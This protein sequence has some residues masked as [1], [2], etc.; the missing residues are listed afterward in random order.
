MTEIL[1]YHLTE[2]PL[3]A[4][5][6][7]LLEKSLQRGWRVLVLGTDA[8]RMAALDLHLWSWRDDSF[9]PHGIAGGSHDEDQP[10]L[11]ATAPD[12]SARQVL[13]LVDGARLPAARLSA[14]ERTCLIFDGNDPDRLAEAREDWKTFTAT[15]MK[16]VYWAQSGGKWLRK[17][18][19]NEAPAAP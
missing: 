17:A 10:V 12:T 16:A 8:A 9:L 13:I 5:L 1:F 3:E 2:S 15:G 4:T 11:L 7:E 14:Y 6:P 18:A 19:A